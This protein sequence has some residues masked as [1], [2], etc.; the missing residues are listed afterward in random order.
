MMEV[1]E[2]RLSELKHPAQNVRMHGQKQIKEY[3]RSVD[4]YGQTKPMV[5]DENGV[6]L[7]GNGLYEA[8]L[9]LGRETGACIV[10]TGLAE[11]EKK[12]LM[13]ADNRIYS[14]GVDNMSVFDEII[15]ELDGDFDIPGYDDDLLN[16]LI[17]DAGNV[18]EV[19]AGY[20]IVSDEDRASMERAGE[21]Y[22][23]NE[24]AFEQNAVEVYP[25]LEGHR[26]TDGSPAATPAAG[27]SGRGEVTPGPN[28][29]APA[30]APERLQRRFIICPRCG[31]RIW[32]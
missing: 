26:T 6:I 25:D 16:S 11:K 19:L 23:E 30:T 18:D 1:I 4:K 29:N 10:K 9:A 32:L 14:L 3:C 7:I 5:I 12:K 21:R 22:Q 17:A 31:E 24:A 8:L 28:E 13:L 15:A 20:G 27:F 2:K